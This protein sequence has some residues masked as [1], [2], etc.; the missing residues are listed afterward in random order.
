ME[1]ERIEQEKPS[2]TELGQATCSQDGTILNRIKEMFGNTT[3][4]AFE[5]KL[6]FINGTG[7][8]KLIPYLKR[9]FLS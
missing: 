5:G 8:M 2:T 1:G 4:E 3:M 7:E 6:V 9:L